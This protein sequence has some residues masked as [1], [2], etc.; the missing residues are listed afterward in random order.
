V[1]KGDPQNFTKLGLEWLSQVSPIPFTRDGEL[2]VSQVLSGGIPP[3]IRTPIELAT[4]QSFFSGYPIVPRNLEKVAPTEQ[5]DEN[6]PQLAVLIGRALG[7][8]PMKLAYGLGG[9][10]GGF[11]KEAIDP[12]KIL[13]MTAQR[14]YRTSGGAKT[15]EAWNLKYDIEVGYSTARQ[16][17]IRAFETGDTE[18]A[19]TIMDNWNVEAEKMVPQ[20][21]PYLAK[22]D[23]LEAESLRRSVTFQ[24]A[25]MAKLQKSVTEKN[26]NRVQTTHPIQPKVLQQS[27]LQNMRQNFKR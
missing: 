17:A 1:R 10:L 13:E 23:P 21:T 12:A 3:I 20:V 4:N 2:S 5:Y 9:L 26:L 25:D 15:N 14:F 11:G 8:S 19:F 6:T 27:D 7:V 18:G 16:Q 24:P 22:D